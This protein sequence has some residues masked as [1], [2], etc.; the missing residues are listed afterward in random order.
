MQNSTLKIEYLDK[1]Q[2]HRK[3]RRYSENSSVPIASIPLELRDLLKQWLARGGNSRWETLVKDAGISRK[4][5]AEQLLDWVLK[6]GWAIVDEAY[7]FGDWW[8]YRVELINHKTLRNQLGLPDMED[9]AEQWQCL[10]AE[11][12]MLASNDERLFAALISLDAMPLNRVI[13]RAQLVKSLYNWVAEGRVGT[14]RDFSFYARAATKEISSAEWNW[15]DAFFSLSEFN[16]EQHTPLLLV[17]ANINLHTDLGV[18]DLQAMPD[19]AALTPATVKSIQFASGKVTTWI[20]IENRTSF[21]RVA[22]NRQRNEGVIWLPGYPPSW[23]K[24]AVGHLIK[25]IP[26]PAQVA[27]DPDPAGVAIALNVIALWHTFEQQAV[28]WK[29]GVNELKSLSSKKS[30]SDFDQAHLS[31]LLSQD[32][33]IELRNL[34]NYMHSSQLK[35][36][37]EGYL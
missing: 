13:H 24:E 20:L 7:K 26:A 34:A 21:E 16:I 35:G 11:L 30:L 15:L 3:R 12:E 6:N 28:A 5:A 33:P 2:V 14:Y 17:S 10:R 37:Q 36:E 22:R 27:C 31:R 18:I 9:I 19:F 25:A 8:P 29:M 23:W 1:R 4:N 32:L